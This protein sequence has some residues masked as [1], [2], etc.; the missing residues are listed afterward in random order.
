MIF[1]VRTWQNLI[2]VVRFLGYFKKWTFKNK[3][4]FAVLFSKS[5]MPREFAGHYLLSIYLVIPKIRCSPI[6]LSFSI[7]RFCHTDLVVNI[8]GRRF[9]RYAIGLTSHMARRMCTIWIKNLIITFIK[10]LNIL[11]ILLLSIY[12]WIPFSLK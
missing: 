12:F 4:V 1:C 7:I 3:A 5:K 2:W 6:Y 10:Y 8:T 11:I 9:S